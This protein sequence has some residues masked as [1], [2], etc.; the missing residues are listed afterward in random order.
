MNKI[1][2]SIV[3]I[4][5]II[6]LVSSVALAEQTMIITV[7]NTSNDFV[8]TLPTQSLSVCQCGTT[9]DLLTLTNTGSFTAKY[10]LAVNKPYVLLGASSLQ[11]ESGKTTSIPLYITA[12]CNK[13]G[14][15]VLQVTVSSIYG[16]TK[17][18]EQRVVFTDCKNTKVELFDSVVSTGVCEPFVTSFNITNVGS[19][20]ETYDVHV[21]SFSEFATSDANA[22]TLPAGTSAKISV[23]Y[24]LPCNVYGNQVL[25]YSVTAR[26]NNQEARFSQK[27]FI[28]Q[29]YNFSLVAKQAVKNMCEKEDS[30]YAV[31]VT[32]NNN[33][34]DS[35]KLSL[36]GPSFVTLS[37][38]NLSNASLDALQVPPHQ[39][40]EVIVH[41][42]PK[43]KKS[44]GNHTF[45]LTATSLNGGVSKELT[46]SITVLDCYNFKNHLDVPYKDIYL[47]GLDNDARP[48]ALQNNGEAPVQ[49]ELV[50]TAPDFMQLNNSMPVLAPKDR[51]SEYILFHDVYNKTERYPITLTSYFRGDVVAKQSF[52]VHVT[53][54]QE[55]YVAAPERESLALRYTND[56]FDLMIRNDGTRYGW[57]AINISSPIVQA[58]ESRIDLG[59]SES[60]PVS[61]LINKEA[62]FLKLAQE[63]KSLIG[64]TL[65]TSITLTHLGSGLTFTY[66]LQIT[67]TDYSWFKYSWDAIKAQSRCTLLFFILALAVV[68]FLLLFIIRLSLRRIFRSRK[69]SGFILLGLMIVASVLVFLIWGI[70]QY[71]NYYT[72]YNLNTNSTTYLRLAEDTPATYDL[73]NF[74]SDPDNDIVSFGVSNISTDVLT[75]KLRGSTLKLIPA[76]DWSGTTI[77]H[78]FAVDSYDVVAQ[79]PDVFVEVLPV[80][81][82][83]LVQFFKKTCVYF[84]LLLLL[85]LAILIFVTFSLRERKKEL[86]YRKELAKANQEAAKKKR[87]EERERKAK[88][89]E[90][91]RKEKA[92]ASARPKKLIVKSSS[93]FP[94]KTLFKSVEKKSQSPKN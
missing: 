20:T 6:L 87:E 82:Y 45:T 18:I 7:V 19:F 55:C 40:K 11:L 41:V 52:N 13:G 77:L 28:N 8:A 37:L 3:F 90:A 75:Y 69:T 65:N 30:Q 9:A 12:P 15:D 80:E 78:L 64:Y 31:V 27:L 35:F 63:N 48:F 79:S 17:T 38:A 29:S 84:D 76:K 32:N 4:A 71:S 10:S 91:K 47:C 70:P 21:N 51:V 44:F 66:P 25:D 42:M 24:A 83:T 74:F 57:Y 14:S 62:L 58:Q 85:F 34:T 93:K 56:N 73:N 16:V 23:H 60:K 61:F 1:V 92:R 26:K 53:T 43:G 81:D 72:T 33:F 50:L 67:F 89:R 54:A 59:R 68:V 94:S 2:V 49:V 86:L 5:A 22:I 36:D 39:S 88:E 46:T